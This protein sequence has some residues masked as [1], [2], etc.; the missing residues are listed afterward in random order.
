[1]ATRANLH[2]HVREHTPNDTIGD[3]A[4]KGHGENHHKT[5]HGLGDVGEVDLHDGLYHQYTHQYHRTSSGCR[6]DNQEERREEESHKEQ[7]G[8]REGSQSRTSPLC[9]TGC[10]LHISGHRIGSTECTEGRSD[11]I[12]YHATPSPSSIVKNDG[13]LKK[14]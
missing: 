9:H 3:A 2:Q 8:H 1:M 7:D 12:G 10:T 6:R 4:R 13:R 5:R 11:G 14:N